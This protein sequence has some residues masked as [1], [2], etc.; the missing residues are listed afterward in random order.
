MSLVDDLKETLEKTSIKKD[1]IEKVL[2]QITRVY[3]GQSVY[4][5]SNHLT[6]YP[7][8]NLKIAS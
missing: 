4:V 1:E 5:R 7:R 8:K 3:G 6:N 2:I